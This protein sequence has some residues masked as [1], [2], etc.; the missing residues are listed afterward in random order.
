MI[1]FETPPIKADAPHGASPSFKD[2]APSLESK[3]PFQEMIPGEKKTRKNPK[4]INT[5]VSLIKRYGKKMAEIPK[6]CNF[7]T[8]SVQNFV[9][10]VKYYVRKYCIS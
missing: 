10:K 5:C 7:L 9:R 1:F 3:A 8:W 4:L 2:E 6:K